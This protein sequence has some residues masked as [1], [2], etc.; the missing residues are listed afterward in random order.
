MLYGLETTDMS[1]LEKY[2]TNTDAAKYKIHLSDLVM[3]MKSLTE[4]VLNDWTSS[5]KNEFISSTS[6]TASSA[7]NKF[8][9]DFIFYY[10]KGLRANKIGIPA[11]NFSAT[12]LPEKVEAFYNKEASKT[13]ILEALKAAQDLFNGKAYNSTATRSSF[14]DYLLHLNKPD[15]VSLINN[16]FDTARAKI[17]LLD[18]S[19]YSQINTD[20]IKMTEAYD[21]LQATVVLLK[22]DMLQAFNISVDYVDA[23]GD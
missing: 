15:L 5:Y 3:Q 18:D 9:N 11:G 21:A 19:F 17:E 22:V 23:D 16:Q 7:A 12:P 10:E 13:L 20:N 14:S 8:V 1:I 2:T 4:T 6:N